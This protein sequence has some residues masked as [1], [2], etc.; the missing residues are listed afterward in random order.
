LSECRTFSRS[1]P[2][3]GVDHEMDVVVHD[4]IGLQAETPALEMTEHE[5]DKLTFDRLKTWLEAVQ[6]PRDEVRRSLQSPKREVPMV[7]TEVHLLLLRRLL[8]QWI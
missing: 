2:G 5:S 4:D 3:I 6:A 8:L 1:T 7:N